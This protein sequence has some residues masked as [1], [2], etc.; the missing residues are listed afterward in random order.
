MIVLAAAT[1]ATFENAP[2]IAPDKVLTMETI[3]K[4]RLKKT[5]NLGNLT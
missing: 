2:G 4:K 5:A 3:A 1:A